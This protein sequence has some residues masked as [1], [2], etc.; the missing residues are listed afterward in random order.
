MEKRTGT[1]AK[2]PATSQPIEEAEGNREVGGWARR[3]RKSASVA[4]GSGL[5]ERLA[6]K[7]RHNFC[8][9]VVICDAHFGAD[10]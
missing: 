8:R 1:R 6:L 5:K 4:L 3:Q 10:A 7:G 2:G 9:N